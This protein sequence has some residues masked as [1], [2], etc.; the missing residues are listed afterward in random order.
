MFSLIPFEVKAENYWLLLKGKGSG[1]RA[2]TWEVPTNSFSEC[3]EQKKRATNRDN[4]GEDAPYSLS[5]I[6]IK[7]K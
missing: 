4:W 5:G 3:I 2:F 6:C 7:G 1:S